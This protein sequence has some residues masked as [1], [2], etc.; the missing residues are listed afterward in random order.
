MIWEVTPP[1][2]F[3]RMGLSSPLGRVPAARAWSS[4]MRAISSPCSVTTELS[5]MFWDL[6]GATV[7]P[8]LR[9]ARQSAA[10][11]RDFPAPEVAP[12]TMIALALRRCFPSSSPLSLSR[13]PWSNPSGPSSGMRA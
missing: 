1:F 8:R 12:R 5:D 2:G 3:R 7:R 10:T 4:W 9:R 13:V 6:K 11:M